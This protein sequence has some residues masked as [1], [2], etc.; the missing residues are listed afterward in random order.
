[1]LADAR[2]PALVDDGEPGIRALLCAFLGC[3]DFD[4]DEAKSGDETLTWLAIGLVDLVVL[5]IRRPAEVGFRYCRRRGKATQRRACRAGRRT[6][7]RRRRCL[8]S[9]RKGTPQGG[10][11]QKEEGRSMD[12]PSCAFRSTRL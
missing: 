12:R 10:V 2:P 3:Y 11:R 8:F 1:M 9:D 7:S 6:R 5:D 4:C